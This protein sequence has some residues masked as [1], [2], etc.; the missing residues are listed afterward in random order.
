[1]SDML[2]L[3][4]ESNPVPVKE[5]QACGNAFLAHHREQF[6]EL[7]DFFREEVWQEVSVGFNWSGNSI[8]LKTADGTTLARMRLVNGGQVLVRTDLLAKYQ[9]TFRRFFTGVELRFTRLQPYLTRGRVV[10]A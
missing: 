9:D 7:T 4:D 3:Q 5:V 6:K 10:A 2:L 1:M 8:T